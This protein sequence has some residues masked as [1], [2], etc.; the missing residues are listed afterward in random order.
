MGRFTDLKPND[1]HFLEPAFSD[2]AAFRFGAIGLGV[3][4]RG[5]NELK[6]RHCADGLV[7]NTGPF[8]NFRPSKFAPR[9]RL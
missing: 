9:Q 1:T 4:A 8:V 2:R 7:K 6:Q 3:T 5:I